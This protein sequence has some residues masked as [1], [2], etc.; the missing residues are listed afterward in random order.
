MNMRPLLLVLLMLAIAGFAAINWGAFTAPTTLSLA[1][2]TIEAPLGLI[3]LG[4]TAILAI[5]ALI[6]AAHLKTTMLVAS[7]NHSRDMQALRKLADQAEASRLTELQR[8]LEIELQKQQDSRT[9]V[10][11]AM[12]SRLEEVERSLRTTVEQNGNSL[13]AH[14]GEMDDRMQR[15][16]SEP[17]GHL[18]REVGNAN[19]QDK[20]PAHKR[21]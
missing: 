18:V 4:A 14:L 15:Q 1:V 9:E 6:F 7:H 10:K 20:G 2:T 13:A 5:V 8:F 3:M 12:L 17:A 21:L 19:W 16:S 11:V